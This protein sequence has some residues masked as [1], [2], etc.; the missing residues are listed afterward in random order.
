[1]LPFRAEI[2]P[3]SHLDGVSSAAQLELEQRFQ[4]LN[5]DR[6]TGIAASIATPKP[7]HFGPVSD[8][9]GL[10]G[11]LPK[12]H[13]P[14][15][16]DPY[17]SERSPQQPFIGRVHE[18]GAPTHPFHAGVT[19]K[20]QQPFVQRSTPSP[21]PGLEH[22]LPKPYEPSVGQPLNQQTFN[23][24]FATFHANLIGGSQT[25]LGA[26]NSA[27]IRTNAAPCPIA[28]P[29]PPHRRLSDQSFAQPTASRLYDQS[30][31]K[32]HTTNCV[33]KS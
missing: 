4:I 15:P 8:H 10:P 12:Q 16:F 32:Q 20:I 17:S 2:S 24:Q 25:P 3:R 26:S 19:A 1:M 27:G 14:P 5:T 28:P 31:P 11:P 22:G 23:Q 30:M 29:P 9:F 21:P 7:G 33:H 13:F 6:N 18:A